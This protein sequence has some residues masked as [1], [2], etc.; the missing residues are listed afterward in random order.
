[1]IDFDQHSRPNWSRTTQV[2]ARGTPSIGPRAPAPDMAYGR[3]TVR[4]QPT[5]KA[6]VLIVVE[7]KAT[8]WSP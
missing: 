2:P 8:G 1:M 3:T 5:R 6:A 4:F 7:L